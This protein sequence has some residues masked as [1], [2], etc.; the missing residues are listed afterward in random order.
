MIFIIATSYE[1]IN[2]EGSFF[3]GE[4]YFPDIRNHIPLNTADVIS[5]TDAI[6]YFNKTHLKEKPPVKL[7]IKQTHITRLYLKIEYKVVGELDNKSY[8][9]RN[10]LKEYFNKK[11]VLELPFCCAV[12][13]TKFFDILKAQEIFSDISYHENKNDWNAI[14][15]L[16]K[17]YDPIEKSE[18]WNN[19]EVLSR[20]AFATSKL[21][22]CTEN[23]KRKFPDKE[24]RKE[25]L[26]Q[27][28]FFRELTIKIRQRCIELS[29]ENASY[30]SNL[31]YTYYQSVNELNTP[32][33]RRDGNLIR[34]AE[35]AIKLF[36]QAL[37]IDDTR[38]TDIYRKAMLISEILPQHTLYKSDSTNPSEQEN[39]IKEKYLSAIEMINAG[40]EEFVKL[41]NIYENKFLKPDTNITK[42]DVNSHYKKYYIK[43]LYHIAQKRLKLAKINFNIMNL[44]YGYKPID[45]D[46]ETINNKIRSLNYANYYI[47]KCIKQDYSKKKEEK[48]LI[49]LVE[50]DNFIPAVYKAY[51]KAV[52]E[53]CLF[54]ITNKDKHLLTAKE[55][56]HKA[57]ELNFPREMKNQ[58]KMFIIEKMATLNLIEGKYDSAI[59]LLEP[60]YNKSLK[61]Q[62]KQFPDYAAFTLAIAFILIGD[63]SKAEE[64][65]Q[66]Y[67]N[68]TN[69]IFAYKFNKLEE[70]LASK[71]TLARKK[72]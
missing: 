48:F 38:I 39:Q 2:S 7:K 3:W 60:V 72:N 21:S 12:D 43:S 34:E 25:F 31:A 9:L 51:L 11:S 65:I 57:I 32:N 61:N 23:L 66:N 17:T 10:A 29:P 28:K 35:N 18:L 13:E 14:Y 47:E 46:D 69:K 63:K 19:A 44:L 59:K 54:I 5:I 40:L 58:N 16:M 53:T 41:V 30:Y 49:D 22:E 70:Y 67:K 1:Y 15:N 6:L 24:K 42:S 55:F 4:K 20:F 33:G 45:I 36:D 52:I 50:C 71:I 64:I 56:Y 27:K 37:L 62:Y 68:T 8:R 26:N